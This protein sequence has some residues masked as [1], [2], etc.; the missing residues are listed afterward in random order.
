[1]TN[2]PYSGEHK[3]RLLQYLS[4]TTHPYLLLL[5]AY[6]ATKAYW[7]NFTQNK[8]VLYIAPPE[9]YHYV[10][11][12]NTGKDLPPFY[13]MWFV[14]NLE[15]V[16]KNRLVDFYSELVYMFL[17]S[18]YMLIQSARGAPQ[19]C[20]H[21]PHDTSASCCWPEG[22]VHPPADGTAV[23]QR[24]GAVADCGGREETK[25]Q[26]KVEDEDEVEIGLIMYHFYVCK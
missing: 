5:P 7:K 10:H 2:P 18:W 20:N 12:E 1:M 9:H 17:R 3:V 4:T 24:A 16:V 21:P 8:S 15:E 23:H 13:S 6:I 11:P 14:G 25:P 19:L 22:P 26:A